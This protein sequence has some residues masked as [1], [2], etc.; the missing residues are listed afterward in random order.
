MLSSSIPAVVRSHDGLAGDGMRVGAK[1]NEAWSSFLTGG[2]P[3][4]GA[5]YEPLDI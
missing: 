4:G 2:D 5:Y 1:R 3:V